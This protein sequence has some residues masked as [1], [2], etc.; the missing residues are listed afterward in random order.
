MQPVGLRASLTSTDYQQK[1]KIERKPRC[2]SEWK[3]KPNSELRG[4]SIANR[5]PGTIKKKVG[6]DSDSNNDLTAKRN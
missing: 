2:K 4:A 3:A 5:R 1:H 6:F